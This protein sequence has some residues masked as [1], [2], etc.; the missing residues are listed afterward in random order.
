MHV[1]DL[2]ENLKKISIDL[3]NYEKS[4]K[5]FVQK[6]IDSCATYINLK[7]CFKKW[8]FFYLQGGSIDVG[9]LGEKYHKINLIG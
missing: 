6:T 8:V 9:L 1:K 4:T 7:C 5:L 3:Q 2:E